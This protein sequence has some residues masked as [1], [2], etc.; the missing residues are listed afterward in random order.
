MMKNILM[1]AILLLTV[2]V[3][4]SVQAET[5]SDYLIYSPK[6]VQQIQQHIGKDARAFDLL[7]MI[8]TSLSIS[9]VQ[10]IQ[11]K[12]PDATITKEKMYYTAADKVPFQ[13]SIIGAEPKV[14]TPYTGKGVKVAV[15]DTG[16]DAQHADL[17]IAGGTCTLKEF[18]PS[19]ISYDDNNGHGTH[20]AGIIAAKKNEYGIVGVA[21]N[22]ELYAV[23]SMNRSGGGE[24]AAIVRGV[25]WAIKN[26]MDIINMSL[27]ITN[28]DLP[29]ELMIKEASK[30]G[31]LVVGAAGNVGDG[32]TDT[33]QYPARYPEVIAV[34]ATDGFDKTV[35][36]SSTGPKVEVAAPGVDITSTWPTELDTLDGTKDGYYTESGT[37]MA[38]PHITGVLALYKERFPSFSA[39]R[40]RNL[41]SVTST[42]LGEQGRDDLFGY[43]R[44]MYKKEIT[45][46]P[47]TVATDQNGK[48]AVKIMNST[49]ISE[50]EANMNGITYKSTSDN[51]W[52]LY[53][54]N[55]T[56]SVD[57]AFKDTD[58]QIINDK[59]SV[60]IN[61]ASFSDL[62]NNRWY[63]P[64]V[65]YLAYNNFIQG[66]KD[67]SFQ[68]GRNILRSEAIALLGR[69]VGLNGEQRSTTFSDVSSGSF[70]SGYIQSAYEQNLLSGF[71]DGTFRPNQPVTRAEMAILLQNAYDFKVNEAN[72]NPF[73]DVNS[74]MVSFE[75]IQA[76]TQQNITRGVTPTT[77][78][79]SDFMTRATYSVF[80]ARAERGD[81]FK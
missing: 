13:F 48:I 23:K 80:I 59:V 75:A 70:A 52:E 38:A 30:K 63:S 47:Y 55:G 1:S 81:L 24:T 71:P 51:E 15:I 4:F 12:Y 2:L 7:P 39:D 77:F 49:G 6:N 27:T 18:C 5:T 34:S 11:S 44:V 60:K 56:T 45:E 50:A 16:I 8:E 65:A 40:L 26:N 68:P 58:G 64:H 3:P 29:L 73:E 14:T 43:G 17:S 74:G 79:P 28:A 35:Q 22:V 36:E 37:S 57:V 25:E 66:M 53:A 78:E 62:S 61:A 72:E 21:P 54:L 32:M 46:I 69:V 67:G 10:Y 19:P 20:V 33:V 31:I 76:I 42:D 9:Q 41:L